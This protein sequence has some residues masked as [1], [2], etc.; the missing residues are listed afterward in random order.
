ME[1]E[2]LIPPLR[3]LLFII[4]HLEFYFEVVCD[5]E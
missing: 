3:F 2:K 5:R 4:K 1:R